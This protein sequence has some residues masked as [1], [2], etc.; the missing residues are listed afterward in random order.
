MPRLSPQVMVVLADAVNLDARPLDQR[1]VHNPR[2]GLGRDL[3]LGQR[4]QVTSELP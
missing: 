1:R 3:R 4:L 2:F